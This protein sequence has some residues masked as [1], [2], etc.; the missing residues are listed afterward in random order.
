MESRYVCGFK[1]YTMRGYVII[2]IGGRG[3]LRAGRAKL[4]VGPAC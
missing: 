3:V 1:H 2:D 4:I